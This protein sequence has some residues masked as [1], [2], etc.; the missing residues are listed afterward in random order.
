MSQWKWHTY[1]CFYGVVLCVCFAFY[2]RTS[3]TWLEISYFHSV[4]TN[5]PTLFSQYFCIIRL[6]LT[7]HRI[8]IDCG[9]LALW[10]QIEMIVNKQVIKSLLLPWNYTDIPLVPKLWNRH[11]WVWTHSRQSTCQQLPCSSQRLQIF[12]PPEKEYQRKWI[13]MRRIVIMS[14][15]RHHF[16]LSRVQTS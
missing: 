8:S 16:I 5:F 3:V 9:N 12:E 4:D 14:S 6:K 13:N 2:I 7:F 15:L 11:H 10:P 1:F